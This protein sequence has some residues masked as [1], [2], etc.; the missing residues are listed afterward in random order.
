MR[1]HMYIE[2]LADE[3]RAEMMTTL[4]RFPAPG[5]PAVT[6][7]MVNGDFPDLVVALRSWELLDGQMI[8]L[9]NTRPIKTIRILQ[10]VCLI[11][12]GFC[13]FQVLFHPPKF[14]S[15]ESL[16]FG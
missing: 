2:E 16:K 9:K 3:R 6:R 10:K 5:Q 14:K 11:A 13:Q 1:E 15:W 4:M 7:A 12:Y 8:E